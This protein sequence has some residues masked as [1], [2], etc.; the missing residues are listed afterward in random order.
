MKKPIILRR[1]SFALLPQPTLAT[2]VMLDVAV[3]LALAQLGQAQVKLFDV[4]IF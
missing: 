1:L 2:L 4:L 3:A